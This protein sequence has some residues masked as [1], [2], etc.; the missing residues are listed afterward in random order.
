MR[1]IWVAIWL[2]CEATASLHPTE[3]PIQNNTFICGATR[4]FTAA[5]GFIESPGYPIRY[6]TNVY[7]A[8]D[9]NVDWGFRIEL[10]W[11]DFDIDGDMP[12]CSGANDDYVEAFTGL[13]T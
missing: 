11:K 1:S 4:N 6:P 13:V 8:Y 3:S 12:Y 2:F 7:C 9:I 5:T 10:T